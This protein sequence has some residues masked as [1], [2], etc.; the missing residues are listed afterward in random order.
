MNSLYQITGIPVAI[1][2][3]NGSPILSSGWP[4]ICEIYHRLHPEQPRRCF[5]LDAFAG[6][7]DCHPVGGGWMEFRC[8]NGVI[9]FGFP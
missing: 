7:T 2:D 5:P 1:L 8:Q 9:D 6:A 4:K 3:Q